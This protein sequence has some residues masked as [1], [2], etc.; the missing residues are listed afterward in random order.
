MRSAE[1]LKEHPY[2]YS[3]SADLRYGCLVRQPPVR[4]HP[5][6]PGSLTPD[7]TPK[8]HKHQHLSGGTPQMKLCGYPPG[9]A[10]VTEQERTP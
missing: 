5:Q 9:D 6:P 8:S 4:R 2:E 1:S 7:V 3:N 10:I